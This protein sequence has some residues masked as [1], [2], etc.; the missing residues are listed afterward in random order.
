MTDNEKSEIVIS[1]KA[2]ADTRQIDA[3]MQKAQELVRTIEKANS[4]AGELAC[5]VKNLQVH[6]V[7]T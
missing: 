6:V 7:V 2:N 1:V 3:A 5:A 4:L